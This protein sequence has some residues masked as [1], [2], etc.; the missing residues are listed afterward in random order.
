VS[1]RSASGIV[2]ATIA[3]LPVVSKMLPDTAGAYA[4]PPLG[5]ID[6]PA[7]IAT[8][9]LAGAVTYVA[10]FSIGVTARSRFR[11]VAV[12]FVVAAFCV[13]FY[14]AASLWFVRRI[15]IPAIGKSVLVS[16]GYKRT[17]FAVTTFGSATDEEMLRQRGPD[18]EQIRKLWTPAS[19]LIA[20]LTLFTFYCGSVL[21]LVY[22]FS[23]GVG[24]VPCDVTD[25]EP[26]SP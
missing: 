1:F 13:I 20:R 23:V 8:V 15:D 5:S 26:I 16:V 2:A 22:A 10:Y 6:V 12:P 17:E 25:S 18:E 9:V 14:L 11:R 3:A 4:F 21:T 24:S 19:V 7:R